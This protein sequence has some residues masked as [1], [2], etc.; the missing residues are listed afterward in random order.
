MLHLKG[1]WQL[2][3]GHWRSHS[4]YQK[5]IGHCRQNLGHLQNCPRSPGQGIGS[6]H[7][8]GGQISEAR[9]RSWAQFGDFMPVCM[10]MDRS[11]NTC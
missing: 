5:G 3:L 2:G 10:P 9:D 6:S 7:L 11:S 8:A 1:W 4:G